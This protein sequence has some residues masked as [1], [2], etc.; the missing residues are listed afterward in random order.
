MTDWSIRGGDR[1]NGCWCKTLQDCNKCLNRFRLRT[2]VFTNARASFIECE[3]TSL[4]AHSK[5]IIASRDAR[6]R[7]ATRQRG[8]KDF[9]DVLSKNRIGLLLLLL[10]LFSYNFSHAN[11][12]RSL[13]RHTRTI[14]CREQLFQFTTCVIAAPNSWQFSAA[15]IA[16]KRERER[17]RG[18]Q[19]FFLSERI[20]LLFENE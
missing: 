15:T 13:L 3:E 5:E 12:R 16:T 10:L 17:E 7:L 4:N 20:K 6:R 11:R 19:S 8:I 9:N 1:R 14:S 2:R 18:K